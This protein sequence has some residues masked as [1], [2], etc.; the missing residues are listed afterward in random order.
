MH[1]VQYQWP[2]P[3]RTGFGFGVF[4]PLAILSRLGLVSLS[5]EEVEAAFAILERQIEQLG[6]GTAANEAEEIA[7]WLHGGLPAIIGADLLDVAA[8]RW[9]GELS[10]NAKQMAA[11][12]S[13]PEFDHNQLEAGANPSGDSGAFRFVLLD[14]PPVYPRNRL[15]VQQTA[16]LL[17]A[18]GRDVRVVDVGGE[19]PLEAVLAA[20]SLGSWTSYYLS[21]LRG[22]EP[23]SN[24]VMDQLKAQLASEQ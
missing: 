5:A 21:R 17:T 23:A 16:S 15:R 13:I 10:E 18:A 19:T 22:V 6:P 24:T 11:S 8:L 2:G 9:A 1:L 4:I 14:A 3:P 20:C 12:Y 7:E